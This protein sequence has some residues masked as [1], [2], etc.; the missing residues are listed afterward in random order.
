MNHLLFVLLYVCVNVRGMQ[1]FRITSPFGNH[2]RLELVYWFHLTSHEKIAM[3]P[4]TTCAWV[5]GD[6][7]CKFPR[8]DAS[9]GELVTIAFPRWACDQ[10]ESSGSIQLEFPEQGLPPFV[11][12]YQADM[13]MCSTRLLVGTDDSD[14]PVLLLVFVSVVAP[15][16]GL[17]A[18]IFTHRFI[19]KTYKGARP[20]RSHITRHV[21][22]TAEHPGTAAHSV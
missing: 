8:F 18:V 19:T 9:V 17:Y 21:D 6:D 20:V 16:F 13:T 11:F 7:T 12:I 10:G 15:C 3:F 4:V 14:S 1:T 2:T 5:N 22:T